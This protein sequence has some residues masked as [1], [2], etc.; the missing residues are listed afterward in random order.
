MTAP[1]TPLQKLRAACRVIALCRGVAFTIK[2]YRGGFVGRLQRREGHPNVR[3]T[4]VLPDVQARG[5]AVFGRDESEMLTELRL[6]MLRTWLRPP[7]APFGN[8]NRANGAAV[9]RRRFDEQMEARR[10]GD[11]VVMNPLARSA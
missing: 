1:R 6:L 9:A 8:K 10:A 5:A 4:D 3:P 2:T 11:D 7:G